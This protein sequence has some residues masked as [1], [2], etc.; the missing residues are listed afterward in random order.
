MEI[1]LIHTT[2][3]VR[4]WMIITDVVPAVHKMQQQWFP[5]YYPKM[6][7]A[8]ELLQYLRNEF[9]SFSHVYLNPK[10]YD[11]APIYMQPWAI[12]CNT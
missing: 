9:W 11:Q 4:D 12:I 7:I 8:F 3:Y 5:H 1:L 10:L 6:D 2:L